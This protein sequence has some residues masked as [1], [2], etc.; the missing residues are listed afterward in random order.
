ML[1]MTISN[2]QENPPRGVLG[3]LAGRAGANYRIRADGARERLPAYVVC[4]L[5]RG[6]W[7]MGVDNGGGGYGDPLTR[8]P[9]R[10]LHDVL[11]RLETAER[12]RDVYGVIFT[13]S[14]ADDSLAVD[15]GAT[16][17]RRAALRTGTTRHRPAAG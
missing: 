4:P 7:I 3:G 9:A 15:A 8:D 16:E 17:R 11:E 12:A 10:V 13:G 6:E 5:E 1:V 2:G 14:A